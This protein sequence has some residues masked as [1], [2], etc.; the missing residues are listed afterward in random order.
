MDKAD[1]RAIRFYQKFAQNEDG[2][3]RAVD[4][5]EFAPRGGAKYSTIPMPVSMASKMTD[6]TW[7]SL[8]PAFEAWKQGNEAP[9][10]GTPLAVW[11]GVSPEQADFLRSNDV[12]TVEDLCAMTDGQLQKIG[13]PGLRTIR[14]NARAWD[15]AKD[16]RKIAAELS[17]KDEQIAALQAQMESLMEMMAAAQGDKEQIK[18]KPG[19]PRKEEDEGEAV[20]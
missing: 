20:A 5:V 1:V 7:E 14:D 12:R 3:A 11:A 8:K 15:A 2:S 17:A 18:R 6:G 4:W 10:T 19:R 9:T 16:D 13:L